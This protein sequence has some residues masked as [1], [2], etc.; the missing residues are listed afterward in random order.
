[1]NANAGK[2]REGAEIPRKMKPFLAGEERAV[3]LHIFGPLKG[4]N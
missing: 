4:G 2:K 3:P 1:M